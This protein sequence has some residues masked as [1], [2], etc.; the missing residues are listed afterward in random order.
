MMVHGQVFFTVR[1][2]LLQVFHTA[3][4]F[5]DNFTLTIPR[6]NMLLFNTMFTAQA[7]LSLRALHAFLERSHRING[8]ECHTCLVFVNMS[9]FENTSEK[10]HF[11]FDT[12]QKTIKN[13]NN[14]YIYKVHHNHIYQCYDFLE[15]RSS[16]CCV[17]P[18]ACAMTCAWRSWRGACG[19]SPRT[20]GCARRR[21]RCTAG[22]RSGS[23]SGR[24]GRSRRSCSRQFP[25][26]HHMEIHGG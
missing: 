16:L 11:F 25:E 12:Y 5:H 24:S 15:I 14:N 2:S 19:A 8:Y 3:S 7:A 10:T 18:V 22:A 6:Q 13:I 23:R 20:S 1:F 26:K 21:R 4:G 17:S 9:F